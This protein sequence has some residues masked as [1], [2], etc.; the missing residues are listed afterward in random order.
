M[1][2]LRN[3]YIRGRRISAPESFGLANS[4][5]IVGEARI[6]SE[7]LGQGL[8]EVADLEVWLKFIP[9]DSQPAFLEALSALGINH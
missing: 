9:N 1:A 2:R 4:E 8:I 6:F 3:R 7:A 5:V